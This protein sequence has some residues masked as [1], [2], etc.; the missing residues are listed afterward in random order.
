MRTLI[1]LATTVMGLRCA[2]DG[3]YPLA[4]RLLGES[5][6]C[7]EPAVIALYAPAVVGAFEF[8]QGFRELC[9]LNEY[10]VS[11]VKFRLLALGLKLLR[12][13]PQS[14]CGFFVYEYPM[15]A[16]ARRKS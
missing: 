14:A 11:R 5:A 16:L 2:C 12:A 8:S 1:A 7:P 15:A 4:A 3:A 10:F 6:P 13:V 9:H